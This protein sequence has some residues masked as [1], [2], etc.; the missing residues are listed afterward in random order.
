[1]I[2][3][4]F[5]TQGQQIRSS[6]TIKYKQINSPISI[7]G[8]LLYY[9]KQRKIYKKELKEMKNFISSVK[10]LPILII[11]CV[12]FA[13]G[14]TA[15]L[16]TISPNNNVTALLL[17]KMFSVFFLGVFIVSRLT[18]LRAKISL[19]A[20]CVVGVLAVVGSVLFFIGVLSVEKVIY[21][22]QTVQVLAV[23]VFIYCSIKEFFSLSNELKPMLILHLASMLFIFVDYVGICFK[24]WGVLTMTRVVF[25]FIIV[26]VICYLVLAVVNS[27][28]VALRANQIETELK[29]TSIAVMISQIQP[30]FLY[31][32]L[33]SIAEL[34]VVDPS[35]AEKATIEFAR[36]LRG[37]M[38]ALDEKKAIEFEDELKHLNHYIELEKLR[39]GKNLEFVYDIKAKEFTLP[40]LTV[41]PLVE[42]AVNHGIRYHKMKGKVTISSYEDSRN[43]YVSI[44]DNG[45]GF[46][47]SKAPDDDRKHIGISNVKY[48]L[49]VMCGGSLNIDSEIGKGT[50]VTVVLPKEK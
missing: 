36:Y 30:H 34:C 40:A 48:R 39:Y 18:K 4:R 46:D 14:C 11:L 5:A 27:R 43:Y 1:M 25:A 28:K 13:I 22:W 31:N 29:D 20:N 26:D 32:S 35:R 47:S 8:K 9:K 17:C 41:Q 19:I 6:L 33:N 50:T 2:A 24:W 16:W 12:V 23:F 15:T 37:N 44:T 42:N 3:L 21:V 49:E 7:L 38:S 10:K 45:V